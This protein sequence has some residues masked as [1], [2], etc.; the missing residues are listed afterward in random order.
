MQSPTNVLFNQEH[1]FYHSFQNSDHSIG[2][3]R[4]FGLP[5]HGLKVLTKTPTQHQTQRRRPQHW[6]RTRK[7]GTPPTQA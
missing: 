5:K 7:P 2:I 3:A 6:V 1:E 4:E